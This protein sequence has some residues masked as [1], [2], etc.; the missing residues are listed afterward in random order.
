MQT[1]T[2]FCSASVSFVVCLSLSF[3]IPTFEPHHKCTKGLAKNPA[4]GEP[5]PLPNLHRT[6]MVCESKYVCVCVCVSG[7]EA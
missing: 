1:S 7:E 3:G 5:V 6:E 4:L 2:I